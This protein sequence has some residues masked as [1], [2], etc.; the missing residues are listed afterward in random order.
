[1]YM[2]PVA[3]GQTLVG[4]VIVQLGG[5]VQQSGALPFTAAVQAVGF[6]GSGHAPATSIPI[7]IL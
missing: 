1:V 4:P 5:G 6:K 2:I 7:L 3:L